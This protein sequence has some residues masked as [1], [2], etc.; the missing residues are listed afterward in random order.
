MSTQTSPVKTANAGFGDHSVLPKDE[1]LKAAKNLLDK[2][3]EFTR[4]RDKL[5]E[6]RR[7]L[8]WT[9]IEKS[10]K[11]ETEAGTK[12]L[13]DLFTGKSQLLAYHFMFW[14]GSQIGCPGCAF[15]ADHFDAVARHLADKDIALVAVARAPLA[16]LLPYKKRMGWQFE[17]VSS[18]EFNYDFDAAFHPEDLAAGP[19][20]FNFVEQPGMSALIKT[21]EGEIYRT[22]STYE[23]G[24]DMFLAT[25]NFIDITPVGRNEGPGEGM[26]WVTFQGRRPSFSEE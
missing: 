16:E 4:M 6:Q 22:Y 20:R 3:K 19:V 18:P 17:W 23:R 2:E 7:A 25:Y 14:P 8:P 1:W 21:P 24:L 10:Y 9:P 5:S 13:T 15:V 11:F 26:G 12:S